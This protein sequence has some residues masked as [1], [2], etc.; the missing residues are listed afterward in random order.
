MA[1]FPPLPVIKKLASSEDK[2][3]QL[4]QTTSF[5][6]S[7]LAARHNP[8]PLNYEQQYVADME[9]RHSGFNQAVQEQEQREGEAWVSD[10]GT[11][12]IGGWLGNKVAGIFTGIAREGGQL[13]ALPFTA[14][15]DAQFDQVSDEM[16]AA[17][18]QEQQYLNQKKELESAE[19]NL[20]IDMKLGKLGPIEAA[21]KRLQIRN[22][23]KALQAPDAALLAQLDEK[24]TDVTTGSTFSDNMMG[25]D[26]RQMGATPRSARERIEAGKKALGF[27]KTVND[28]ISGL[29]DGIQ[30]TLDKDNFD[31]DLS[32]SWD[33]N[34]AQFDDAEKS[35]DDGD[36]S[37]AALSAAKGV[38]G[39]VVDGGLDIVA[40]PS[41]AMDYIAENI[42]QL[43]VGLFGKA[44]KAL[45]TS[46]NVAYGGRVYREA[47]ED[48]QA[49]NEGK[50]PT[51]DEAREMLA[52]SVSAA[53]AEHVMDSSILK[54]FK[55]AAGD[56]VKSAL[57]RVGKVADAV[58]T[59]AVGE[60]IT[61]GYQTAVEE[62][63]SKLDYDIDGEKVFKGAAIG[64]AAGGGLKGGLE[65]ANVVAESSLPDLPSL[66]NPLK[67]PTETAKA[68]EA[69]LTSAKE[70]G[71]VAPLLDASQPTYDPGTAVVALQEYASKEG[72]DAEQVFSQTEEL[73]AQKTALQ[74]RKK[75][76]LEANTE[77][78]RARIEAS[79]EA[80]DQ[81]LA[82]AEDPELKADLENQKAELTRQVLDEPTLAAIEKSYAAEQEHLASMEIALNGW[83]Q[84]RS[85]AEISSTAVEVADTPVANLS[86]TEVADVQQAVGQTLTLA[87]RGVSSLPPEK[88]EALAKNTDNALQPEQRDYLLKAA[89]ARRA[90]T[91]AKD[92][93]QVSREVLEGGNGNL[94]LANYQK[95]YVA[96]QRQNDTAA[97][98]AAVTGLQ[99]FA[100]VHRAKLDTL[101]QA[102]EQS[103]EDGQ[104]YRFLPEGNGQ[105]VPADLSLTGKEFLARGGI[106]ISAKKSGK[107]LTAL[108]AEVNAL[109]TSAASMQAAIALPAVAVRA[110]AAAKP[111]PVAT[112]A[113]TASAPTDAAGKPEV[114]TEPASTGDFEAEVAQVE[115]EIQ[116]KAQA[117]QQ[118]T[119][120]AE[121]QRRTTA[122]LADKAP[123]AA[124]QKSDYVGSEEGKIASLDLP[125]TLKLV[126][127]GDRETTVAPRPLVAVKDFA[128]RLRD[129]SVSVDD[130][131]STPMTESQAPLVG[132]FLAVY[133]DWAAG[134]KSVLRRPMGKNKETG[135]KEVATG[136]F[137]RDPIQ[138]FLNDDLEMEENTQTALLAAAF[139]WISEEVNS[140][141]YR[142]DDEIKAMLG[143][144]AEADLDRTIAAKLREMLGRRTVLEFRLG[145]FAV[146]ALGL[147]NQDENT[148]KNELPRLQGNLGAHLFDMLNQLD[149]IH[150]H[151]IDLDLDSTATED[152]EGLRTEFTKDYFISLNRDGNK[153]LSEPLEAIR[154]VS[155][156][157]GGILA[158]LFGMEAAI[159]LPMLA[160]PK[161]VQETTN[162]GK[163]T[164][165]ASVK[166]AMQKFAKR[167]YQFRP[168][169]TLLQTASQG[170]LEDIAGIQNVD[171]LVMHK[172]LRDSAQAANDNLRRELEQI[173][174][175][176]A[177]LGEK[178]DHFTSFYALPDQW[179]N[180]RIGYRNTW[181]NMQSSKI[182]RFLVAPKG[183]ESEVT[184]DNLDSFKLRV[185]EG[186]D[187]KTDSTP[188]VL[189]LTT[190]D[191]V[192]GQAHIR[193]AV[194][195]LQT[196]Q[197]NGQMTPEAEAT[198]ANAVQKIGTKLHAF[199][200]LVALAQYADASAVDPINGKTLLLRPFTTM[201][202]TEIDG[203][204][205]GPMLSLWLLGVMGE[206][207]AQ[208]GGFYT[209]A[210]GVTSFG[211]WKPGNHDL[212]QFIASKLLGNLQAMNLPGDVLPAVHRLVGNPMK[213]GAVTSAGRNLV[214]NP[215]TTL[216]YG[217]G[218]GTTVGKMTD[219]FVE[220]VYETV[221]AIV[222][223]K[224]GFYYGPK[225]TGEAAWA[226]FQQDLMTLSG[227]ATA[228]FPETAEAALEVGLNKTQLKAL[229]QGYMD[230]IGEAVTKTIETE[231]APYMTAR[232]Q[233]VRQAN[234]T[235]NLYD[236]ARTKLLDQL[237]EHLMKTGAMAFKESKGK[238]V[239]LRD[240]TPAEEKQA[241]AVL[242]DMEPRFN[243]ALSQRDGDLGAGIYVAKE[244]RATTSNEAYISNV[245]GVYTDAK[246][247]RDTYHKSISIVRTETNPGVSV[248]ANGV[249]SVD[250]N[251]IVEVIANLNAVGVHDALLVNLKESVEAGQQLNQ[252]T[253][254]MLL[255]Y[256]LPRQSLE[257]LGRTL[258]GY[259][260]YINQNPS[261]FD[262]QVLRDLLASQR[263][264]KDEPISFKIL[265]EQAT[266]FAYRADRVRLNGLAQIG[267]VDQYTIEAGVFNV[268]DSFRNQAA[269]MRDALTPQV[270]PALLSLAEQL[271]GMLMGKVSAPKAKQQAAKPVQLTLDE[272]LRGKENLTAGEVIAFLR[273]QI[274]QPVAGD[275]MGGLYQQILAQGAKVLKDLPVKYYG[276]EQV[277]EIPEE[278]GNAYGWYQV[279]GQGSAHI[280]IRGSDLPGSAVTSELVVHEV[281]HALVSS[282]I[283]QAEQGKGSPE[284]VAAVVELGTIQQA[285]ADQLAGDAAKLEQ[286]REALGSVQEFVTWGMTNPGFQA[287]LKAIP[288]TDAKAPTLKNRAQ[289]FFQAIARVVFG[290]QAPAMTNALSQL[291]A[292]VSVLIGEVQPAQQEQAEG[293]WTMAA[294]ASQLEL[295]PTALF[296]G[297]AG[298]G[299]GYTD[300]AMAS[301]VQELMESVVD[302]VGGP[303]QQFYQQ[304][305]QGAKT[306]ADVVFNAQ[307]QGLMPVTTGLRSSGFV[308]G[309]QQAYAIEVLTLALQETQR[310]T[311]HEVEK[312]L[313]A[314]Y[315]ETSKTVTPA[316][317]GGQAQWDALFGAG[318]VDANGQYLAR[319]AAMALAYPPLAQ[320]MGFTTQTAAAESTS[321]YGKVLDLFEQ[322]LN[323]LAKAAHKAY[324]GQV[325][326][327]KLNTLVKRLVA[328]E[329]KYQL[330]QD[331][332]AQETWVDTLEDQMD[333]VG[334]KARAQLAKF[335]RNPFFT[336]S[337][338]AGLRLLGNLTTAVAE[339]RVGAIVDAA[340]RVYHR[341][342]DGQ[343]GFV[344]SLMNEMRGT[345]GSNMW[346]RVM[347]T[348]AKAR[349]KNRQDINRDIAKAVREG[350]AD[351]GKNLTRD[352]K[353]AI[354][355][356]LLRSGASVLLDQGYTLQQIEQLL[357]SPVALEQAIQT[358]TGKLT[359]RYQHYYT[360]QANYLGYMLA[361]S[362]D[363]GPN[364]LLN[365]ENIARL[366]NTYYQNIV[367]EAEV[368]AALPVVDELSTLRALSYMDVNAKELVANL[369]RQE[370]QR[371]DK[372]NGVMATLML[373]KSLLAKAKDRV[374]QGS[375]RLMRKGY[376]PEIHNPHLEVTA[377]PVAERFAYEA[378]GY[379]F[380][381]NLPKDPA[382][383]TWEPRV[384]MSIEKVTPRYLSGSLSLTSMKAQG[385][386][387][388]SG[389]EMFDFSGRNDYNYAVNRKI[390][391]RRGME[392]QQMF[393]PGPVEDLA[394][395]D[396]FRLTPVTDGDGRVVNYRYMMSHAN[397]DRLLERTN[398]MDLVLGELASNTF[399]KETTVD[400]NDRV[401]KG[402]KE[403]WELEKASIPEAYILVGPDS[404]DK[405]IQEQYRLLPKETRRTIEA[406]W[407]GPNMMMR[408]DTFDLHFGYRKFSLAESMMKSSKDR[409]RWE[410]FFAWLLQDFF[411]MGPK[412]VQRILKAENLIMAVNQEIKD[413]FVVKSGVTTYWNIVSNLSLLKLYGVSV[414]EIVRSHRVA[415]KGARDWQK[416]D[417]ELRR[418]KAMRDSGFIV[419][420]LSDLDQQIAI[421]EDQ[422]ARSP[423]REVMAMGM[424]PTLVEDMDT[425]D[426]PY[427]YKNYAAKKAEK[428]LDYVPNFVKQG[429]KWVY[430][431]HDT[432]IY[433]FLS[434]GAQL[435]DFVA[436]YTLYEHLK[437]RRNNPL[438]QPEAAMA[439][440]DAF[441]NYD[442]LSHRYLQYMNDVGLVR[443]T[444]YYMRIQA[445][446]MHLYQQNPARALLLSTI[447]NY[448]SGMQTV[449]DS[450]WWGRIGLPFEVGPLDYPDAVS[451]GLVSKY[452]LKLF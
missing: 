13:A 428:V 141:V 264:S 375:E 227:E 58:V 427:S 284:V 77:E 119:E 199:E 45:L 113:Q 326:D 285:V 157:T 315:R 366:S 261:D 307:Q 355:N 360:K 36:K 236:Q 195:A 12:T 168:T 303:F 154:S 400:H 322:L 352:Q 367:T 117:E 446:L 115:A 268:P 188:D 331:R 253:M 337:S 409:G 190:F 111:T 320:K 403:Q 194:K 230:S 242:K 280:G 265:V 106:A 205:N 46:S 49:N 347:T 37:N 16:R 127:A 118:A 332:L 330:R 105:W 110:P 51:Q 361:T 399:D 176:W 70:T 162:S 441:I 69:A 134:L 144:D 316:D 76:L 425:A 54:S 56:S 269:K 38:A 392:I 132:R 408:R 94:G 387:V 312:Q 267:V 27:A 180:S 220:K 60:A 402:L 53:A 207:F 75:S 100:Q 286:Y 152:P 147:K 411:K 201:L 79:V 18:A 206:K 420:S 217:S 109:E 170:F 101:A 87:M 66:E 433:Q 137:F 197:A 327:E 257:S 174:N 83:K 414:V 306:A 84:Q 373:H 17:Y 26:G 449:M 266:R 343:M 219:V 274:G 25:A 90:V 116:A 376:V 351:K 122:F 39:L 143:L 410:N 151:E 254:D 8:E 169:M 407:G 245:Q 135:E 124:A 64:A 401:I 381:A 3:T 244:K 4:E 252:Q 125:A 22:Q 246:G 394:K 309:D 40:N 129:Q 50:L 321:L 221:A 223:G 99:N 417:S 32:K 102:F 89:A 2:R 277:S 357:R 386:T 86:E 34:K 175:L 263:E 103:L 210:S 336:Q 178:G 341:S 229:R 369:M 241:L 311:T 426:D 382:D 329:G 416:N 233:M 259:M 121:Q 297:L 202:T 358:A 104:T 272:T 377:V 183:W 41:A 149:L 278:A 283:Q 214:K 203:K 339:D 93:D 146:Q 21:A 439:S 279:D 23:L 9:A 412:A 275:V 80:I 225:L 31:S 19:M 340:E 344:A 323:F 287:E 145:Q 421:L 192:V 298:Q 437:T 452:L 48:Y 240:L 159:Q 429:A 324:A 138:F 47:L 156:G 342:V 372:G 150:I 393:K 370:G 282:L 431:T 148:P 356:V 419:G 435:S 108:E 365:V 325:A 139:A 163:Q 95:N 107:L 43:A 234:L 451:E 308:L 440:I 208:M 44:G 238:R 243:T 362:Q 72:V 97:A 249:Q 296:E 181:A 256:S 273:T 126:Q 74:D 91:S 335:G 328:L 140:P 310:D 52:W 10:L 391:A 442:H 112:P 396:D 333:A 424:M 42:P 15:G 96:A 131:L 260:Q 7:L 130:F 349:E 434:Q 24:T 305:A 294:P 422:Q 172:E 65:L 14:A 443:F 78:G 390:E 6:K 281:L 142:T 258:T 213:D 368:Q 300:P 28:N 177:Y 289:Q 389:L 291:F 444:K 363:K 364:T 314:L 448:F 211:N 61:E 397:R 237:R 182:A 158:D 153:A 128:S 359:S 317:L 346:S 302:A 193:A 415:L 5:K 295:N 11:D 432:P 184:E 383:V 187:Q 251:I 378:Q 255:N 438:S 445:V 262:A 62:N 353:K 371:Q 33:A 385:T 404:K 299:N 270:D 239:P 171:R 196:A 218:M 224:N 405:A 379:K 63:L 1:L 189:T 235:W 123:K 374:F 215:L 380:E 67:D 350:F 248:M 198:V 271:D 301:K 212:Y 161:V 57:G 232:K 165:A 250:G 200:A 173:Q 292:R 338:T 155:R 348:V 160:A 85:E 423:V 228:L 354:T 231:M 290:K 164:V 384:L 395:A 418:L 209:K 406:I 120:Q 167:E 20:P 313:L 388:H 216:I 226:Q 59:G 35:W 191:D 204:T 413:F 186:L 276:A 222:E 68:R 288:F 319:F 82:V 81:Q 30:N 398:D 436:R 334:E 88:M 92:L 430:M 29:T 71:E 450:A 345:K 166:K 247:S 73:V 55:G 185:L 304:A 114:S 447:E 136:Q 133:D 179:K 318:A 293:T 98:K